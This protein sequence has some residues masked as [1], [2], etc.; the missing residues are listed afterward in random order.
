MIAQTPPEFARF[1]EGPRPTIESERLR[2][3]PFTMDDAP[4]VER[5]AGRYEVA[6]TL[7][8]MPHPYPEGAAQQWIAK[9]EGQW[10]SGSE[11]LLAMT[12]RSNGEFLGAFA[13][14]FDPPH[15]NAEAGY[16]LRYDRWG[17][18][19]TTEAFRASVVWGFEALGLHR[20]FARHMAGNPASGAVM[21]KAGLVHEGTLRQHCWKD[22]V[23][24]DFHVY[25]LLRQ[26]YLAARRA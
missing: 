3:R 8:A 22:G 13:F 11:L 15:R 5:F 21:R 2:L 10:R 12:E 17:E 20:I 14:K 9:H 7:L 18:G 6:R 19:L 25:G 1:F 26:E 24:H 16:W 4:A 23:A